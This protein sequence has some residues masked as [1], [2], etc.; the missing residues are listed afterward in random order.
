MSNGHSPAAK[1]VEILRLCR[2][3]R[4]EKRGRWAILYIR[5]IIYRD[6][7]TQNSLVGADAHIG[8]GR[9]GHRPLQSLSNLCAR[10]LYS[11]ESRE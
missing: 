8:P 10:V 7:K 6:N 2:K 11:A 1:S 3:T 4:S 5:Y 9:C